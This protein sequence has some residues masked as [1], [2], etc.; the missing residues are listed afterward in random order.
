MGVYSLIGYFKKFKEFFKQFS[1]KLEIDYGG[2]QKAQYSIVIKHYNYSENEDNNEYNV[3]LTHREENEDN[4]SITIEKKLRRF[5]KSMGTDREPNNE[6]WDNLDC[7][8]FKHKPLRDNICKYCKV[9]KSERTH[10]CRQ[11]R[12]C[13]R[14]MDHHCFFVN[15]CIG[16][17]NY[18]L[19]LTMMLYAII[20]FTI[21]L[22]TVIETLRILIPIY[23][24]I[25]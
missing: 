14:R 7:H 1:T 23:T 11:C 3:I 13:V 20:S 15:N 16:Y 9:I 18:K 8:N 6:L 4:K 17:S 19:F 2:C 10:H 24:V 25:I 5:E 22:V 21:L 12:Q